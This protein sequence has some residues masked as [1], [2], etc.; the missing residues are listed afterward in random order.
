MAG[1]PQLLSAIGLP[2]LV[3]IYGLYTFCLSVLQ[4]PHC[5]QVVALMAG[6][7]YWNQVTSRLGASSG[8]GA[9]EGPVET[10]RLV[11]ATGL[12]VL[13]RFQWTGG[14]VKG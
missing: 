6:W 8:R 5:S 10:K 13:A 12:W 9:P 1:D 3:A 11:S 7:F 4:S 2:V 14:E